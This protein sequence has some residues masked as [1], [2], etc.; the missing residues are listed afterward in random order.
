MNNGQ[1][2]EQGTAAEPDGFA[3]AVAAEIA[4]L[5][6]AGFSKASSCERSLAI[7]A[8]VRDRLALDR[9]AQDLPAQD[10]PEVERLEHNHSDEG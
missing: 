1:M 2:P 6:K 4:T 10:R 7:E 8:R 5:R 9:P 3:E